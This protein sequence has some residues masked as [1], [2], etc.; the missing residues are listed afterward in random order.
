MASPQGSLSEVV[1]E[2]MSA[3]GWE[4]ELEFDPAEGKTALNTGINLGEQSGG[5]LIVE[6]YDQARF[7]DVFIYFGIKC[8][9]SKYEEMCILLNELHARNNYG[10]FQCFRG[11]GHIRWMHRVDFEGGSPTGRSVEVIVGPGWDVAGHFAGPIAA[12]ALTKQT[13]FEALRDFDE[14]QKAQEGTDPQG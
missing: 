12:V 7:I 5:R 14:A 6:A 2:F 13:A 4:D 9:E 8:K 10:R 1:R 11:E 3:R